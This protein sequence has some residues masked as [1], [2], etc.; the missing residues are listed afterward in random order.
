MLR[1]LILSHQQHACLDIFRIVVVERIS[2]LP[3]LVLQIALVLIVPDYGTTTLHGVPSIVPSA[4]CLQTS[5][6]S[7]LILKIFEIEHVR[8]WAEG[9]VRP[10][11]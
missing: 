11:D 7:W 1:N 10:I 8:A 9:I 5:E 4:T 2:P 6:H 3:S